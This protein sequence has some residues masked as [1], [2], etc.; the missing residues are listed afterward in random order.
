MGRHSVAILSDAIDPKRT[1][2]GSKSRTAA[3]SCR[4][5]G[6]YSSHKP[7]GPQTDSEHFRFCPRTWPAVRWH[8]DRAEIRCVLFTTEEI[9]HERASCTGAAGSGSQHCGSRV[10]FGPGPP[11]HASVG[12]RSSLKASV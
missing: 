5:L 4:T 9:D 12:L 3:V 7:A 1:S 10:L 6:V 8:S 11:N 2:A